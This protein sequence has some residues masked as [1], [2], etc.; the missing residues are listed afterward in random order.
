MYKKI[1]KHLIRITI[2]IVIIFSFIFRYQIIADIIFY[3]HYNQF[4]TVVEM[5]NEIVQDRGEI[6]TTFIIKDG[7]IIINYKDK[8]QLGVEKN[9]EKKEVV[10]ENGVEHRQ[11]T[12]TLK[13]YVTVYDEYSVEAEEELL[14]ELV[15]IYGS[16]EKIP[17][18]EFFFDSMGRMAANFR[19]SKQKLNVTEETRIYMVIYEEEE[20]DNSWCINDSWTYA[21]MWKEPYWFFNNWYRWN[22]DAP[23]G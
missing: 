14:V 21:S 6:Y 5:I 4:C 8:N 10:D 12:I 23:W 2:I 3:T 17:K 13:N 18:I 20:F 16:K 19:V 11:T 9:E 1:I 15:K 7:K 22:K